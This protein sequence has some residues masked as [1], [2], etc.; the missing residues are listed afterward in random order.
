[1]FSNAPDWAIYGSRRRDLI[2]QPVCG[3]E[4]LISWELRARSLARTF[5]NVLRCVPISSVLEGSSGVVAT[6]PPSQSVVFDARFDDIFNEIRRCSGVARA[7]YGQNASVWRAR[8]R[9]LATASLHGCSDYLVWVIRR[10]RM[11]A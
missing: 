6:I 11:G 8:L 5:Q 3:L 10:I 7:G 4:V 2:D 1:M 9:V